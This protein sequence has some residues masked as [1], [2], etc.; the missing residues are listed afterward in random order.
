MARVPQLNNVS[1]CLTYIRWK[2][3][4]KVIQLWVGCAELNSKRKWRELT[5]INEDYQTIALLLA[6]IVLEML[7]NNIN[8]RHA[9]L[10]K[11]HIRVWVVIIM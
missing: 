8:S 10:N 7:H 5:Y 1:N 4:Q 9:H 6:A 2:G 11:C 3:Q